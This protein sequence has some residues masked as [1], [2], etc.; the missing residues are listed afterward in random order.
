MATV[1]LATLSTSVPPPAH[2]LPGLTVLVS[3][4]ADGTEGQAW[5]LNPASSSDGRSV[6]FL[7]MADDLVPGDGTWCKVPGPGPYMRCF[8]VYVKDIVTGAIVK[9]SVASDG[10]PANGNSGW[11]DGYTPGWSGNPPY[12]LEA[13]RQIEW[14]DRRSPTPSLSASGAVVAFTSEAS[15]I[16]PEQG[17][18]ANDAS[19]SAEDVFVHDIRTG[20]TRQVSVSYAGAKGNHWSAAPSIS[21][22]GRRV[23]F[24]S[25]A[26]NLV[27]GD[28]NGVPDVF[29]HD[30]RT[31]RTSRISVSSAGEQ[32]DGHSG[33]PAISPDGRWVAYASV[34]TDLAPGPKGIC[35]PLVGEGPCSN[36]YLRDMA[37]HT[38]ML[39]RSPGDDLEG[40]GSGSRTPTVSE[41]ARTIAFISDHP[42]V[43]EP[44]PDPGKDLGFGDLVPKRSDR[45]NVFAYDR[46]AGTT[47][48][49]SDPLHP[50]PR[51]I[52][53]ERHPTV[54]TDGRLVAFTFD[55]MLTPDDI[56]PDCY[57]STNLYPYSCDDVYVY[58][59]TT[60]RISLQSG[61]STGVGPV[62]AG[63]NPAGVISGDGTRLAFWGMG[64]A[65]VNDLDTL[66]DVFSRPVTII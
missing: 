27:P 24:S 43:G 17:E 11:P 40:G 64:R 34:A 47:R 18:D 66:P 52:N 37:S 61:D 7:A 30:L 14:T 59:L 38:T 5:A 4:R 65:A 9:A 54:T 20:R 15:N 36:I 25:A 48:R 32:S 45:V 57:L 33:N 2:A 63:V 23:V 62:P 35:E 6:A 60:D 26:T 50:Q 3:S 55:W 29:V 41:D 39:V 49:L 10:T 44:T 1:I 13:D 21:A 51:S 53:R 42:L 22:D 46:A 16:A 31:G 28:T 12:G 58:D 8:D 19:G 56:D